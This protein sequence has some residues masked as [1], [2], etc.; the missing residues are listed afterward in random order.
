MRVAFAFMVV[1]LFGGG[2]FFLYSYMKSPLN[3]KAIESLKI[4]KKIPPK[5]EEVVARDV[6]W[7]EKLE[8]VANSSYAYPATE[9]QI[10][11]DFNGGKSSKA[12]R[13]IIEN[14]DE[15][16][17]FCLNQILTQKDIEYAY[18]KVGSSVKLILFAESGT[19][20]E[21]LMQDLKRYEID[22]RIQ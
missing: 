4:E 20:R 22:Y 14:L 11:F 1:L 17:F 12:S 21:N 7:S 8:K 16:K 2:G 9:M 6:D 18:S 15:Y 19:L 5:I 13:I 10:R 3:T